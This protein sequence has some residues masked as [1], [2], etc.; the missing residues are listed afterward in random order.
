MRISYWSSDVCSSDLFF[1]MMA[2]DWQLAKAAFGNQ[3]QFVVVVENHPA[4]ARHAKVFLQQITREQI[5]ARQLLDRLTIIEQIGRASCRERV[6][7]S[8]YISVVAVGLQKKTH[9]VKK[10]K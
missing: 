5:A 8:E 4:A 9:N 7:P 3:T 10:S 6:C 2:R 1:F